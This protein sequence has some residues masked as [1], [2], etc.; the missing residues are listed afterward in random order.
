M[1]SG[2]I[3]QTDDDFIREAMHELPYGIY[4]IGTT[5]GEQPN[6]MI[7][8]WVMQVSFDPRLVAVA[9][10]RDSSSLTRIRRTGIFTVNLL[11]QQVCA[12]D[13]LLQGGGV[14]L[15]FLFGLLFLIEGITDW[16]DNESID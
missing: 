6:G 12:T 11:G 13:G 7:A 16:R 10:E 4:I 8:D 3:E 9:F 15:Q 1:T 2:K 14:V 5:D